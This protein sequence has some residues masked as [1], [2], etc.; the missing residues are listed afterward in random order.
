MFCSLDEMNFNCTVAPW[1]KSSDKIKH[2]FKLPSLVSPHTVPV[3]GRG[4][5]NM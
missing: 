1:N 3:L 2:E 4:Q 5:L